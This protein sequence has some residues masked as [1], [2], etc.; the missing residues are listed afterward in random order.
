MMDEIAGAIGADTGEDGEKIGLLGVEG[1]DDYLPVADTTTSAGNA[2]SR[3]EKGAIASNATTVTPSA[4]DT[5]TLTAPAG[6]KRR[7]AKTTGAGLV[8]SAMSMVVFAVVC[9]A[10]YLF[11]RD[12]RI[13]VMPAAILAIVT[14]IATHRR[15]TPVK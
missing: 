2:Q 1:D 7:V 13:A 8:G 3:A 12:L 6:S 9:A 5:V 15:A 4:A 10:V 14:W 11:T